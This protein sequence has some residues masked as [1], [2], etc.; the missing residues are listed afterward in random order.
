MFLGLRI[1]IKI[2]KASQ[3]LFRE[4]ESPRQLFRHISKRY[5]NKDHLYEVKFL[6]APFFLLFSRR[7]ADTHIVH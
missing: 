3:E 4:F 2:P 1:S 5:Q 6:L 7:Y